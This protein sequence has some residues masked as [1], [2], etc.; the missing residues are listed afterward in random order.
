MATR[1]IIGLDDAFGARARGLRT[2]QRQLADLFEAASYEEVIPPLMERPSALNSGA[3]RFLADQTLVF[4]DPADAGLLAV[5]PDITPQIARIAASRLLSSAE[6]RLHYSGPVML[7]RPDSRGGSRQPWQTGI[8]CLGVAGADGDAEVIRLAARSM[9]AAGFARP[10]LQVGHIGLLK[11][12]VQ[13]TDRSLDGW[14]EL[15]SRRSPE[16][17]RAATSEESMSDDARD[18]LMSMASGRADQAWIATAMG[19][20][21]ATFDAAAEELLALVKKVEADMEGE[22]AIY[23]DAGVMPR[24]L[25]HSGILFAG[26]AAGVSQ[27]LLH[28]G[29]YDAMMAAHGRD[30]PATGFSCDL[31]AWLDALK[32]G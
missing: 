31:W 28:G 2:L 20:F 5:R 30:M 17:L 14:T 3:G 18:A 12:L 13:G 9:L 8:E 23:A 22:V 24:F 19:S 21:D 27:A 16:D 15:L 32:Q 4:S 1:P 11:A 29:R 6:L 25:Y 26:F 7:A 10:V